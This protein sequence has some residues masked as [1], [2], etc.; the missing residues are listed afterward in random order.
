MLA[1]QGESGKDDETDDEEFL[2]NVF[3]EVSPEQREQWEILK[4]EDKR[5]EEERQADIKEC[6]E[7]NQ[8][9]V[10]KQIAKRA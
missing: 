7:H 10:L 2:R 5:K 3:R 9:Y 8:W 6:R 1:L 4:E